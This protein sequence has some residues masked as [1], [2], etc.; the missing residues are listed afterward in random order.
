MPIQISFNRILIFLLCLALGLWSTISLY[1]V[2]EELEDTFLTYFSRP[3]LMYLSKFDK[4][5]ERKKQLPLIIKDSR[6]VEGLGTCSA[7]ASTP[8]VNK[9]SNP[10]TRGIQIL[11][12]PHPGYTKEARK[13]NIQGTVMLA[14]TFKSNDKI[15][16]VSV[17]K[18]LPD[19]LT[20]RAI[21]AAKK[22]KF[23][24]AK[25][26]GTPYTVAKRIQ[27]NFTIH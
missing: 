10:N 11:S 22:I 21:K 18:D 13:N 5:V 3:L 17:V 15:G 24:P 8:E 26:N 25:K 19:G 14:V 7:S 2:V 4:E 16:R 27:Y 20:E 6:K 9:N 23:K 1:S 12:K